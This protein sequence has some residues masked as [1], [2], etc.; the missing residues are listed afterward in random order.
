MAGRRTNLALLVL[1]AAAL[2]TGGLA[3]GIGT[4]WSRWA[5]IAHGVAGLGIVVLTPWKS[6]IARRGLRRRRPGSWASISLAVALGLALVA[7][8]AH[9][10]GLLRSAAGVTAMQ[11]HVG[12]ALT[13]IPFALWHLFAR[14]VRPHRTDFSRRALLR[15]AALGAASFAAYGALSGLVWVTRLPGRARRFTGSYETGSFRPDAMPVTQ[16][17][18]D[19]VP[20]VDGASW[21]LSIRQ[22]GREVRRLSLDDLDQQRERVRATIDCTG[23]WFATQVW[24]GVRLDALLGRDLQGRSIEVRSATGYARRYPARDASMLWLATR[25]GDAPLSP[26]H[27]YPARLVAP[28]RRGFWWVKWVASIE[29][30][31]APWWLQPPF[32][33]T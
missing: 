23:G 24:E 6:V 14:P 1:L 3:Y 31:D 13:S 10:T 33:L 21:V 18:N 25:V 30:T 26:G 17:L 22:N 11:I 2:A 5:A 28:G 16:W 32:P 8:M 29:V 7:G 19:S 12:A 27:G 4:E 15:G 9:S 20:E